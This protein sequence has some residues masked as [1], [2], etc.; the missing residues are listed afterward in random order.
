MNKRVA[1]IYLLLIFLLSQSI[2]TFAQPKRIITLGSALTET[3]FALGAGANIVAVDVTSEYPKAAQL[4]PKV[5]RNRSVNSEA[6]VAYR[7]DLVLAPA[8]DLSAETIVH[9]QA[10]KIKVVSIRQD[11]SAGGCINF[12]HD[13]AEALGIK[14]KGD[15]LAQ[16]TKAAIAAAQTQ[17]RNAKQASPKVLFIYARGTGLMSVA[18]RGS[19]IDAIIRMAGGKNAVHEF[20]DF[21]PYTTEALVRANPDIILMFDF[22]L[23]SLGGRESMMGLPAMALTN[24]CKNHRILA[25]DGPLLINFSSRL[26]EAILTLN[27]QM[28]Q[29]YP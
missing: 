17:I 28:H 15:A 20:A 11:F 12:I 29:V 25:L 7:P 6:L 8:G 19:S 23:S 2:T 10:V 14:T 3:V 26:P 18:G 21:K 13:I 4:L 24:A 1:K 27:K 16:T 22:G 9:L 5:S